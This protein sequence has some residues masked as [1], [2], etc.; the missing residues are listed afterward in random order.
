[1]AVHFVLRPFALWWRYWPQLAAL[2]LVGLLAR[3]GVI[4]LAAWAGWGNELWASLIMPFAGLARLGS[5]VAMFLALRSAIP[6]LAAL[7]QGSA[8]R[9]DIFSTVI[10]PFFAIYLAWQLFAEDWLAFEVAALGYRMG[11]SMSSPEPTELHPDILPGGTVTVVLI[12]AA[13]VVR[14]V[15]GRFKDRFPRWMIAVRVYVDAL[16]VFLTLSFAASRDVTLFPQADRVVRRAKDRGVVQRHSFRAVF[17]L[18]APGNCMGRR[19]VGPA[20]GVRRRHDTAVVAGRR[21]HHLRR[22]HAGLARCR[23]PVGR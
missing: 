21:R 14:Y 5:F 9:I 1:M 20:N 22:D 15:L 17:A 23:A 19:D 11:A 13:L 8:R 16:W 7:P 10:V 12:F 3:R 4:E 18:P 2:Y 6:A